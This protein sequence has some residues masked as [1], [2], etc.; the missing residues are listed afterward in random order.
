MEEINTEDGASFPSSF[1]H[2]TECRLY[3]QPVATIRNREA[4][5]ELF[6]VPS[7]GS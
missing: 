1:I 5:F 2:A 3:K 6:K 7:Y 4:L